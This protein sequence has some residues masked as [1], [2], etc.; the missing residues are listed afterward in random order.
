MNN[1]VNGG[2]F[3]V[4]GASVGESAHSSKTKRAQPG[5]I[6]LKRY[7]AAGLLLQL[8]RPTEAIFDFP[9]TRG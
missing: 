2:T 3:V 7:V 9:P 8:D 4:I 5:N 1:L 6:Q